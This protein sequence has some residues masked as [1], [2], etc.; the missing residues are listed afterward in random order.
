M[1]RRTFLQT[2][3]AAVAA[4]ALPTA[5][6]AQG[7]GLN[8][9]IT[10]V[11]LRK[12]RLVRELGSNPQRNPMPPAVSRVGGQTIVEIRTNQG[13]VGV[14]PGISQADLARAKR[15]LVGEDPMR[16]DDLAYE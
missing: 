2:M 4:T 3:S 15:I 9:K 10:D 12:V 5:V 14:G 8:L 7:A 6:M 13:L 11:K 16:V 1:Q